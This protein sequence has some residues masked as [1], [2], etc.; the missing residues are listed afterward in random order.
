MNKKDKKNKNENYWIYIVMVNRY[1]NSLNFKP[2]YY[3]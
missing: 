2:Q 3:R 1:L